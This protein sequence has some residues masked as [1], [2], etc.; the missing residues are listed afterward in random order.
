MIVRIFQNCIYGL[1]DRNIS[2]K[3]IRIQWW[4]KINML[5]STQNS[6]SLIRQVDLR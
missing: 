4:Y 5:S 1:L 3:I 6:N 2:E